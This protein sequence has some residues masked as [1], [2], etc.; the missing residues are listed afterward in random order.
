MYRSHAGELHQVVHWL[1]ERGVDS[2]EF[3]GRPV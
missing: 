2:P 1:A 3:A